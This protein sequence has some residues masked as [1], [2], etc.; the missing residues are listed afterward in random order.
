G[1]AAGGADDVRDR[2]PA[3]HDPPG[4]PD[5]ADGGG[6]RD[7]AR[8]ARGADERPWHVPR[9]GAAADGVGRPER[10][11]AV[12]L[13]AARRIALVVDRH[14][15]FDGWGRDGFQSQK[16]NTMSPI[17]MSPIRAGFQYLTCFISAADK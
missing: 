15:W 12:A 13:T 7:R 8:H 1:D 11:R 10:G 14:N 9:D 2:A 6:P 5:P 17:T 16:L 3:V 4:R